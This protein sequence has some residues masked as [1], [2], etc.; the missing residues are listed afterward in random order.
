MLQDVNSDLQLK[1]PQVNVEIERDRA[2]ALGVN[3]YQIEDA[4]A[5]AY[6]SREV[7]TIYAPNNTYQV[8]MELDPAYQK[9]PYAPGLLYVRSSNG[10]LVSLETLAKFSLGTGTFVYQSFRTIAFGNSLF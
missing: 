2:A 3:L 7:S 1:N 4:L 5:A 6:A 8:I 9:D 10:S